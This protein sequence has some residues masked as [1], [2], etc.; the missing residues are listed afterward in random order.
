MKKIESLEVFGKRVMM[1]DTYPKMKK[2]FKAMAKKYGDVMTFAFEAFKNIDETR[3]EEIEKIRKGL[4]YDNIIYQTYEVDDDGNVIQDSIKL[5]RRSKKDIEYLRDR[6]YA[7][8][9]EDVFAEHIGMYYED[10]DNCPNP[11]YYTWYYD[12]RRL[13]L[14][15]RFSE[16]VIERLPKRIDTLKEMYE[17]FKPTKFNEQVEDWMDGD[18]GWLDEDNQ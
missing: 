4:D 12:D 15:E 9:L 17:L 3:A 16:W 5:N 18:K 6:A 7:R 1:N 14:Y 8:V 11:D 13:D 2:D 10:Y